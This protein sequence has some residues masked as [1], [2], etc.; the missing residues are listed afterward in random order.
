M[1]YLGAGGDIFRRRRLATQRTNI[2]LGER[3]CC[4]LGCRIYSRP[5]LWCPARHYTVDRLQNEIILCTGGIDDHALLLVA[6]SVWDGD[7]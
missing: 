4:V 7:L 2:D 3:R 6:L 5:L 1:P